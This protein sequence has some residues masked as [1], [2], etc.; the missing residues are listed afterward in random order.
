MLVR[1]YWP[2]CNCGHRDWGKHRRIDA[3]WVEATQ[4]EAEAELLPFLPPDVAKQSRA[5]AQEHSIA[6]ALGEPPRPYCYLV[7][8]DLSVFVPFK[9]SYPFSHMWN[10]YCP[11]GEF[12]PSVLN[13]LDELRQF[14]APEDV[15]WMGVRQQMAAG[16]SG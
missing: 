10:A 11:F 3:L 4:Q 2:N 5:V 15:Q 12:A 1:V 13:S 14:T 7:A 9:A 6:S 16:Q 8:V